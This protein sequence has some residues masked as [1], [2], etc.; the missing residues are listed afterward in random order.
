MT[1]QHSPGNSWT[2]MCSKLKHWVSAQSYILNPLLLQL[3]LLYCTWPV[4]KAVLHEKW[5]DPSVN[6]RILQ[7]HNCSQNCRQINTDRAITEH[8]NQIQTLHKI[9]TRLQS[10][11]Q[12]SLS[13][14]HSGLEFPKCEHELLHNSSNCSGH[15]KYVNCNHVNTLTVGIFKTG[16]FRLLIPVKLTL[17]CFSFPPKLVFVQKDKFTKN[18]RYW[19]SHNPR[20]THKVPLLSFGICCCMGRQNDWANFL[21]EHD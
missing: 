15:L 11:H 13:T 12:K 6:I 5:E 20:L 7:A 8:E 2:A 1:F 9:S 14:L 4:W 3:L 16:F 18:S 21:P 10:C 17:I 19:S